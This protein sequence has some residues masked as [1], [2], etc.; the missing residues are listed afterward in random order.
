VDQVGLLF[1]GLQNLAHTVQQRTS[2]TWLQRG[3][4]NPKPINAFLE[5]LL[6]IAANSV[7]LTELYR[8]CIAIDSSLHDKGFKVVLAT[9]LRLFRKAAKVASRDM[10]GYLAVVD[11]FVGSTRTTIE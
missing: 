6:R 11:Q 8:L 9:L 7:P 2:T 5:K 1:D 10:D 3:T 4:Y